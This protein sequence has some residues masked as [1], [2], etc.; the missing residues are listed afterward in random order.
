MRGFSSAGDDSVL[1]CAAM[2]SEGM[3]RAGGGGTCSL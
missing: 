3:G 1:F 2:G